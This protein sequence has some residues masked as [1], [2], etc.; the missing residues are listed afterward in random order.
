MLPI[1]P[2]PFVDGSHGP[3]E[4]IAAPWSALCCAVLVQRGDDKAAAVRARA[5]THLAE[6]VETFTK[7]MEAGAEEEEEEEE[8]GAAAAATG[9][10]AI[11]RCFLMALCGAHLLKL[12]VAQ[13]A[14]PA[15]KAK[16]AAGAGGKAAAGKAKAGK[17]GRGGKGAAQHRRVRGA[18]GS[19]SED[20]VEEV[21]E[22]EQ[23][24]AA[25]GNAQEQQ[26]AAE[27][28]AGAE[29]VVYVEE[30]VAFLPSRVRPD[31]GHLM[32]LAHTRLRDDKA[33]V[34]RAALG[35]LEGCLLLRG[36]LEA[37][38]GRPPG[39]ED[40]AAVEAATADSLVGILCAGPVGEAMPV[41]NRREWQGQIVNTRHGG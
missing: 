5:L 32:R 40:I 2:Q 13:V 26:G 38:L 39:E 3:G 25:G 34:R 14:V 23:V 12:S 37:P 30:A 17:Q 35:V 18:V 8:A 21:E 33:A 36:A 1:C 9:A 4:D 20:E 10:G 16:G 29:E 15:P 11:A 41:F 7:L 6:V 24:E 27:G 28:E 22:E 19:D 31:L